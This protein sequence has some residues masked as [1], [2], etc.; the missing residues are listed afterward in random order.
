MYLNS[1]PLVAAGGGDTQSSRLLSKSVYKHWQAA[2][3]GG[4]GGGRIVN[5]S[6]ASNCV[7]L[8][9]WNF[10]SNRTGRNGAFIV[11][12]IGQ[13]HWLGWSTLNYWKILEQLH[14]S[15]WSI[16]TGRNRAIFL[17]ALG[18]SFRVDYTNL[19]APVILSIECN[20]I[21]NLNNDPSCVCGAI[22]MRTTRKLS[23]GRDS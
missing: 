5:D 15:K 23:L 1:V 19:T 12:G 7:L 9:S 3:D 8:N 10:W 14:W 11:V 6:M 16:L 18:H 13:S 2:T 21:S 17:V 22:A 4:G 20:Y